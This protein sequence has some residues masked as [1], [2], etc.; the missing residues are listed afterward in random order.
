[1][2]DPMSRI[3]NAAIDLARKELAGEQ[4]DD[5]EQE[6]LNLCDELAEVRDVARTDVGGPSLHLVD[7]KHGEDGR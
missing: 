6:I 3:L 5:D 4:L 2:L 1:M 7:G